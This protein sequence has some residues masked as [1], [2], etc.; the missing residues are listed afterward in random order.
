M[1][2]LVKLKSAEIVADPKFSALP[3]STVAVATK[4]T[5]KVTSAAPKEPL[6]VKTTP[7]ATATES[8]AI[9]VA[10]ELL[11]GSVG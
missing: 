7:S 6:A 2:S 3:T 8:E 10:E 5:A 11:A 4:I 9:V 1:I